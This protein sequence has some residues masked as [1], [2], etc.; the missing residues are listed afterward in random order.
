MTTNTKDLMD[1]FFIL[2]RVLDSL[3]ST[4]DRLPDGTINIF[5]VVAATK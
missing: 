1:H 2:Q 3:A 5:L 4:K